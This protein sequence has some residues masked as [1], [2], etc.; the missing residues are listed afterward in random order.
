MYLAFC[1][2]HINYVLETSGVKK[3][4]RFAMNSPD[5]ISLYKKIDNFCGYSQ[6]YASSRFEDEYTIGGL[7]HSLNVMAYKTNKSQKNLNKIQNPV[8]SKVCIKLI[9]LH[10]KDIKNNL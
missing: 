3:S 7:D 8:H 2:G 9:K 5:Y 6:S 1:S 4:N 10:Q